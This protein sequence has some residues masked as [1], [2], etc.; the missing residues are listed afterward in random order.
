[1]SKTGCKWIVG[2]VASV[3]ALGASAN[4]FGPEYGWGYGGG[5]YNFGSHNFGGYNFGSYNFGYPNS[6]SGSWYT[7]GNYW[8][9][10]SRDDRSWDDKYPSHSVAVPEPGTLALLGAGLLACGLI[11]RRRV[12]VR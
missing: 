4:S 3:W 11:R 8:S 7:G 1:M 12:Q 2:I 5:S 6:W 10:G 9:F